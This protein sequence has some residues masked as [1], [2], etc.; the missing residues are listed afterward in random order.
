MTEVVDEVQSRT[1]FHI[2]LQIILSKVLLTMYIYGTRTETQKKCQN[3]P[4]SQV[5]MQLLCRIAVSIFLKFLQARD[6]RRGIIFVQ[7]Q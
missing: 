3:M 6:K 5:Q 1:K 4:H 7:K 2:Q